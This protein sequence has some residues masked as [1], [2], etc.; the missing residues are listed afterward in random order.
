MTQKEKDRIRIKGQISEFLA[1]GG[2]IESYDSDD[3]PDYR[4]VGNAK[5][6]SEVYS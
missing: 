5:D 2:K 1:N 3:Q 4:K 6:S